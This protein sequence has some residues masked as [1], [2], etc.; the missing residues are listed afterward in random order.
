[1][2]DYRGTPHSKGTGSHGNR[3]SCV[4][5]V[6]PH[7]LHHERTKEGLS[8][9]NSPFTTCSYFS[10][11]SQFVLQGCKC[12]VKK[13]AWTSLSRDDSGDIPHARNNWIPCLTKTGHFMQNLSNIQLGPCV[14]TDLV[15]KSGSL[16]R[17]SVGTI[18][19]VRLFISEILS[20]C[21]IVDDS[22]EVMGCMVQMVKSQ[23]LWQLWLSY[24]WG[25]NHSTTNHYSWSC[26]W[27]K[28]IFI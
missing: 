6:W 16:D 28:C 27:K 26:E 4:K 18:T 10:R 5:Q 22:W 21:S 25:T 2:L 8:N 19:R 1:M 17:L 23:L 15:F 9:V 13:I 24:I 11:V 7:D 14:S 3:C 20:V 12:S